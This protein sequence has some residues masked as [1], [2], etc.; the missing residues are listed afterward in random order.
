MFIYIL[1]LCSHIV[2][3]LHTLYV[4]NKIMIWSNETVIY[5]QLCFGWIRFSGLLNCKLL[6]LKASQNLLIFIDFY[7]MSLPHPHPHP[8]LRIICMVHFSHISRVL[9]YIWIDVENIE[10]MENLPTNSM[11][12]IFLYQTAQSLKNHLLVDFI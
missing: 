11:S 7:V 2:Y 3:I 4:R 9:L 10:P 12:C 1:R 6:N 5:I 8:L